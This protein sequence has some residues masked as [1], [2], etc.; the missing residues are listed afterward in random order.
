[1]SKAGSRML[2]GA[3]Q[4]LAYASGEADAAGYGIHTP[5]REA[6]E[7]SGPEERAFQRA[8]ETAGPGVSTRQSPKS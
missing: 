2:E 8:V 6:L 7:N 3:R 1:M 4:A 5:L